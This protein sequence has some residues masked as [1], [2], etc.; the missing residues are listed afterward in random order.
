[1]FNWLLLMQIF[2]CLY[3]LQI[4]DFLSSLTDSYIPRRWN[5]AFISGNLSTGTGLVI[6][7]DL[8]KCTTKINVNSYPIYNGNVEGGLSPER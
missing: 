8:V 3:F 7:F 6:N 2:L 5:N 4:F 1:M